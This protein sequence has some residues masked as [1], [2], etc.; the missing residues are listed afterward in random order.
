MI[1]LSFW[2]LMASHLFVHD[3]H[4]SKSETAYNQND[5]AFQISLHIFIDDFEEILIK[6]SPDKLY[7]G[8]E[9]EVPYADSV[10][11]QYLEKHFIIRVDQQIINGY[12]LG[13]ELSEDLLAYWL[14]IEIPFEPSF[15]ELSITYDVLMDLYEDQRNILL[16]DLPGKKRSYFLFHPK[17]RTETIQ[18]NN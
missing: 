4:I 12:L 1:G 17:H 8:T 14:Y 6:G 16:L 13:K 5:K 11:M 3:I 18:L 7:L 15:T 2:L 9:K 10:M